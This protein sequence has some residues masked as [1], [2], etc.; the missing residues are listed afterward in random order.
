MVGNAF[1]FQVQPAFPEFTVLDA[2]GNAAHGLFIAQKFSD[3]AF[4]QDILLFLC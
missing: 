1:G 4:L 2:A 3:V